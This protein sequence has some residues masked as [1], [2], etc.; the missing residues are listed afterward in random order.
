MKKV[1]LIPA[2]IS[3]S[4]PASAAHWDIIVFELK[5]D[6]KIETYQ[7]IVSDLNEWGESYGYRT[8]LLKPLH[9]DSPNAFFRVG[10]S[11]STTNFG[12]AWDAWRDAQ[13]D[14][15]STPAKLQA[16]FDK[17]STAI[18]RRSYDAFE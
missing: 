2:L 14:A 9:H 1:L 8:T 18:A 15:D 12:S 13:S 4:T 5:S 16:R 17:C 10:I 7:E 6:C 11:D 3:I